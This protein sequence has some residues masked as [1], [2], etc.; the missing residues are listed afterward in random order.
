MSIHLERG[1]FNRLSI[2]TVGSRWGDMAPVYHKAEE[3][4][5][6]LNN[7]R[8]LSTRDCREIVVRWHADSD[9]SLRISAFRNGEEVPVCDGDWYTSCNLPRG[10]EGFHRPNGG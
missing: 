3:L 2:E 10:H 6:V 1:N 9:T 4:V 7:A 8:T 5:R